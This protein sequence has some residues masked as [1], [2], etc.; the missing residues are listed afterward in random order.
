MMTREDRMEDI[1]GSPKDN[2]MRIFFGVVL[3]LL[4]AIIYGEM[5]GHSLLWLSIALAS[6]GVGLY[7][8]MIGSLYLATETRVFEMMAKIG[9][10][11]L[12]TYF[13]FILIAGWRHPPIARKIAA[14]FVMLLLVIALLTR[15]GCSE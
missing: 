6:G 14:L 3:F 15:W 9:E 5:A 13:A 4:G 12:I 11:L 10:V 2:L 8:I 1:L 7:L